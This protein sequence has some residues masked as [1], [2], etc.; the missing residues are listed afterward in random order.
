V[1]LRLRAD[2]AGLDALPFEATRHAHIAAAVGEWQRTGHTLPASIDLWDGEKW[3]IVSHPDNGCAALLVTGRLDQPARIWPWLERQ[4]Q[5]TEELRAIIGQAVQSALPEPA[6]QPPALV[7]RA[8]DFDSW[9][10]TS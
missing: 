2:Q 6:R 3:I 8:P 1:I 10:P 7:W 9:P 4:E 5:Y